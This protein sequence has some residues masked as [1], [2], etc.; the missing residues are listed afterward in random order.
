MCIRYSIT[1]IIALYRP[2]P[3]DSI[4]RFIA[5]SQD[6]GKIRYLHPALE[7]ILSVT[8]GLSLIHI[9]PELLPAQRGGDGGP[10]RRL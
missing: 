8:Y 7:P 9:S 2:G 10:V 6:P 1:A 3:M 5:C 4:P